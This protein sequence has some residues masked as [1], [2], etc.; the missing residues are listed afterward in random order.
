MVMKEYM[1]FL[2]IEHSYSPLKCSV[3]NE[4]RLA[5]EIY[6]IAKETLTEGLKCVIND[7]KNKEV[8]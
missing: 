8:G 5:G 3:S 7:L 4:N 1:K 6:T 2:V